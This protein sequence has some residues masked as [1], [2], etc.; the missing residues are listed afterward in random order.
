VIQA[1]HG[2]RAPGGKGGPAR[3]AANKLRRDCESPAEK[4]GA[5][6]TVQAATHRLNR[7]I[8][9]VDEDSES[10]MVYMMCELGSF[11]DAVKV[12]SVVAAKQ[13]KV[14][15][16]QIQ[17]VKPDLKQINAE[18]DPTDWRLK[19]RAIAAECALL[20]V[21]QIRLTNFDSV[22]AT[23]AQ[24]LESCTQEFLIRL[25]SYDPRDCICQ[26]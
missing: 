6:F 21:C 19:L 9:G 14:F 5:A 22:S 3:N 26:C 18:C 7:I 2:A 20:Q 11:F 1:A 10:N 13:G 17:F 8:Y 24:L 4:A 15:T 12:V 23:D 16:V 25:T